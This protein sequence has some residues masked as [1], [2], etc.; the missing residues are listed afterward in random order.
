M[1]ILPKL[2]AVLLA[3]GFTPSIVR[4]A[5]SDH[6]MAITLFAAGL[7]VVFWFQARTLSVRACVVGSVQG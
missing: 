3:I 1:K 7:V 4:V 6:G 2:T 5:V